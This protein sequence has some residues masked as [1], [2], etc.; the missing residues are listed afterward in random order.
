MAETPCNLDAGRVVAGR[1]ELAR[2]CPAREP[3]SLLP[4]VPMPLECAGVLLAGLWLSGLV[5]AVAEFSC[6]EF[7][8]AGFDC[9]GSDWWP[10]EPAG[11]TVVAS[12]AG[13]RVAICSI[14]SVLG[15]GNHMMPARCKCAA[16][17][18]VSK[19]VC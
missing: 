2:F 11:S 14:D 16:K 18:A 15:R 4:R 17:A 13:N 5:P 8:C 7:D 12:Q 1:L 19:V 3:L 6:A 10:S 9:A